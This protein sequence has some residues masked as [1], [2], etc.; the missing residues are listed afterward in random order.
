MIKEFEGK[1]RNEAIEKAIQELGLDRDELDVEIIEEGKGLFKKGPVKIR[2]CIDDEEISEE[3]SFED[4]SLSQEKERLEAEND[5]E[6]EVLSFLSTLVEKMGYGS[7]VYISSRE[8]NK[9]GIEIDSDHSGI[10]IGKQGKNLDALQLLINV[11]AGKLGFGE[12]KFL[13]DIE[14]YRL[15]RENALIALARKTAF[16]LKKTKGSKLLD[17]M[18]PYERRIIHTTIN[19]FEDL[20]TVSEGEGLYK[21]VRIFYKEVN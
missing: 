2:I 9:I 6:R 15:K 21:R 3:N 10:L 8:E 17:L 11:F 7:D 19:E 4:N 12:T 5:L 16:Y 20:H 13:I 14:N 1:N 18:N